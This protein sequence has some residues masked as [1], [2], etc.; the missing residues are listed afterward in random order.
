MSRKI[1]INK[2]ISDIDEQKLEEDVAKSASKQKAKK[3]KTVDEKA[4]K[5]KLK[6]NETEI[7]RLKLEI[8]DLK[9]G[10]LRQM[11][12][13]EN[14]RKRLEREKTEYYQSALNEI[15]TEFLNVLDNF[16]RALQSETPD[17]TESFREGVEMIYK[18]YV[19]VLNK[20]GIQLID[21]KNTKFDP[22]FHQAFSTEESSDVSEPMVGEEYQKG[23]TLHG[24]LFRPSLVKVV[25][26]KK[27]KE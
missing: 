26:P 23:Y 10:Y 24:R 13:K 1:E 22:R 27:E 19:S 18:M 17:T 14:L 3:E 25:V 6:K 11:A 16:E 9:E 12:D 4:L 20:Q 2:D 21:I 15:L 8:K 5:N 7:K